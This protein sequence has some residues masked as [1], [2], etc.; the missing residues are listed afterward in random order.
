M[1]ARGKVRPLRKLRPDV[2]PDLERAINRA[3]ARRREDRFATAA[4]MRDALDARPGPEVDPAVRPEVRVP[5]VRR[6]G[7]WASVGRWLQRAAAAACAVLV[8]AGGIGGMSVG[9][10][11]EPP[12]FEEQP[13]LPS[14]ELRPELAL[15]TARQVAELPQAARP[16]L[17]RAERA[18]A[19][20]PEVPAAPVEPVAIPLELMPP[21]T[22]QLSFPFVLSVVHDHRLGNCHGTLEV[23][24]DRITYDSDD[25]DNDD[26]QWSLA[27]LESY[28]VDGDDLTLVA[29]ERDGNSLG[30]RAKRYRFRLTGGLP[31]ELAEHLRGVLVRR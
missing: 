20:E 29:D 28:A 16:A 26:R 11:L 8:I 25:R 23:W 18:R 24:T 31:E 7:L 9:V 10:A 2:P 19:V 17:R 22:F 27:D 12:P 21:P 1:V 5:V 14:V 4:D 13:G 6:G 3:M 30:L 15:E